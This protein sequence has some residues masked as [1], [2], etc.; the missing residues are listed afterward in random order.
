MTRRSK[1][2]EEQSRSRGTRRT[3]AESWR[4][5]QEW[6]DDRRVQSLPAEP[7]DITEYLA[8]LADDGKAT[9]TIAG[10]ASAILAQ[11]AAFIAS[12]EPGRPES[13][14]FGS[15]ADGLVAIEQLVRRVRAVRS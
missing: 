8:E 5:F 6:C 3:Y 12:D 4:L 15:L 10:R 1:F 13:V 7:R 14:M 2:Y 9:N 11:H